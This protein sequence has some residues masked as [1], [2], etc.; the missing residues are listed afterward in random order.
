MNHNTSYKTLK[1]LNQKNLILLFQKILSLLDD[2][3][4]LKKY[5]LKHNAFTRNRKLP[6]STTAKLLFAK[7]FLSLSLFLAIELSE[8]SLVSKQAFSKARSFLS[9][10]MFIDLNHLFVYDR[11]QFQNLLLYKN[12]FLLLAIDG[13]SAEIPNTAHL[14]NVFGHSQGQAGAKEVAR[15]SISCIFDPLNKV[16][17][18]ATIQKNNTLEREMAKTMINEI[19]VSFPLQNKKTLYLM[20]RGYYSKD[21]L[22]F[23]IAKRQNFLFRLRKDTLK[24][25]Q[26]QCTGDELRFSVSLSDLSGNIKDDA[27]LEF[28]SN[29]DPVVTLRMIRI[30]LDSGEEEFLLTNIEEFKSHEFKDLY[31]KRWGIE[32]NYKFLKHKFQ[33][34]NFS[35]RTQEA[36]LQDFYASIL[37][38][39]FMYFMEMITPK[40]VSHKHIYQVNQNILVGFYKEYFLKYILNSVSVLIGRLRKILRIVRRSLIMKSPPDNTSPRKF[41]S[42]IRANSYF[43]NIR[44][45]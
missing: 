37:N 20:D 44:P 32:E 33:L 39:N 2:S 7:V 25:Y 40:K 21:L 31:F 18:S 22:A 17:L 41:A 11:Y 14:R 5:I 43:T 26:K 10:R 3:S 35:G 27:T 6:L 36:I 28:F 23:F 24:K 15:A 9:H 19:L 42:K 12:K 4:F 45:A 8:S 16:I 13:S 38:A 34:E 30:L 1:D 29:Q